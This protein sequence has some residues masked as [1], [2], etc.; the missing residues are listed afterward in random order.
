MNH[1]IIP[2]LEHLAVPIDSL[3]TLPGNPQEGDESAHKAVLEEFGQHRVAVVK[4]DGTIL[5]GNHMVRF[6]KELGWTHVAAVVVDDDD[7]KA[8]AR[9]IS[10]NRVAELSKTNEAKLSAFMPD[11][12]DV[13]YPV[14]DAL[15][16]DEM[17]LASLSE[18]VVYAPEDRGYTPPV[19]V[20]RET[21]SAQREEGGEER[22]VAPKGLDE[23]DLVA[24]GAGDSDE[25]R[26]AVINYNLVFDD[27]DQQQHWYRFVRW[28][29]SDPLFGDVDTTAAKLLMFVDAHADFQ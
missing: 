21:V 22:L 11:L 23:K 20:P 13:Y 10:D 16:W 12:V 1:N 4:A 29:R 19:M 28:L 8:K 18:T 17:E 3:K 5:V 27:A 14:F 7:A 6:A 26:R 15:G 25:K 24:R 9:A 2:A